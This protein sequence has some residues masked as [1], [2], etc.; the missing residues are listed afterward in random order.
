M[1]IV[2]ELHSIVRFLV[3]LLAIVGIVFAIVG[4]AQK[5]TPARL[6]QTAGSIFLGLYD[7]QMLLGI[8]VILLGGLT[9]A[10]HPIVMF[11]GLVIAHGLQRMTQ[12]AEG[13]NLHMMRLGLYIVPLAII[14]LGLAVINRLPV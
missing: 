2:L 4:L 7:L 3:L 1:N 14:L 11:I 5:K 9:N 6:D 12:R 13:T 8:L 10:L